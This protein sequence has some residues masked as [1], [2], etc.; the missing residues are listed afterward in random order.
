MYC[1]C[2]CG[3]KKKVLCAINPSCHEFSHSPESFPY[4]TAFMLR[5]G[6]KS[7]YGKTKKRILLFLFP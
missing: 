5:F 3:E 2:L 7:E 4:V 6:K 1:N